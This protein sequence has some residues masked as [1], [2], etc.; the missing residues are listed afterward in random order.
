MLGNY[1]LRKGGHA[2]QNVQQEKRKENEKNILHKITS[3]T[4]II[5]LGNGSKVT[6][7]VHQKEKKKKVREKNILQKITSLTTSKHLFKFFKY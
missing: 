1:G 5:I 6:Q 2:T 7:N 4:K 3:L